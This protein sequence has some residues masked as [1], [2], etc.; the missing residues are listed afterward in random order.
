MGIVVRNCDFSLVPS[1]LSLANAIGRPDFTHRLKVFL[2]ATSLATTYGGPAYSVSRLA[3]SLAGVGAEIGLWTADDSGARGMLISEDS[4]VTILRGSEAEALKAFGRPDVVHDNGIWLRHNHRLATIAWRN[5]VPRI[6]STRGMLEPWA[7]QHKALKKRIAWVAY[8]KNDL[9]SASCFHASTEVEAANI[10]ALKLGVPIQVIP[11]GV[12]VPGVASRTGETAGMHERGECRTALFLGRI[13]PVK[14]L[15]MLIE[16]WNRVRPSGWRLRIV[17]PDEA[18]HL[19][20]L[21]NA[22]SDARLDD[23]VLFEGAVRGDSKISEFMNADLFILPTHSESFGMVVAEALSFGI[24]VLTTHA[25]PWPQ[26]GSLNCGW[27]INPDVNDLA[28]GLAIATSTDSKTLLE[29]GARGRALM[30]DEYRWE[31]VAEKTMAL[32][33]DVL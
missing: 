33:R 12:D 15:P 16:A 32:Y 20:E 21:R 1:N 28:R 13:Y 7:M 18:G 17:G 22:V 29:M 8:Q 14:G 26:L 11:N 3:A 10:E 5:K 6:V 19:A 27:R 4:A 23:C 24:P 2:A 31:K 25:A 9:R 30:Q